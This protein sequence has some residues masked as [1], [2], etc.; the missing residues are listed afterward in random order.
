ML[1]GL[2]GQ[3]GPVVQ[4][5]AGY[6]H[7]LAVTSTG[8]LYAFGYN[9]DGQLGNVTSGDVNPIPLPVGLPGQTGPVVQVAAGAY[10]SLA[11]TSTGQLYA[12]GE[13]YFGQ[14]GNAT[15][16]GNFNPNPAPVLVGLPGQTGPV[17]QVAAGYTD[18]LAV[19]S[20]GQLYAFGENDFGELGNAANSGTDSANPTPVLVGMPGGVSVDTVA[21]GSAAEHSLVVL[22]D[23]AVTT[24]MLPGG[25]AGRPYSASLQASGGTPP[26][27]WSANGLAPGLAVD[28]STGTIAGTP[29]QPGSYTPTVT[30]TDS[31]GIVA[32][33]TLGLAIAPTSTPTPARKP[34]PGP[35]RTI[36]RLTRLSITPGSVSIA[37]RRVHGRCRTPTRANRHDPSCRRAV[38]LRLS[39]GLT[40]PTTLTLRLAQQHRGQRTGNRCVAPTEHNGGD[41]RCIRL[42]SI[43]GQIVKG[44]PAGSH[45][46]V[47]SASFAG[48]RL[49]PGTYELTATPRAGT[50]KT[51][52]FTIT[53]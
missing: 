46:L 44:T 25:T 28:A 16:N 37:G 26:G 9:E 20:T 53:H 38:H 12:F 52:T 43:A 47:L 8:Q 6:D 40:A 27:R 50:P 3:V 22:A 34:K 42:T 29:T 45:S 15:N 23:L 18:S 2:P 7:S 13:N 11:L 21:R 48:H 51:I 19:T 10:H 31:D 36:A 5:A 41:A 35:G 24:G 39:Y 33:R 4:V 17:V 30:V 49:A 14:L 1:V 32:S